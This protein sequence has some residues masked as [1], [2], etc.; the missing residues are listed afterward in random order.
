MSQ[1]ENQQNNKTSET[2]KVDTQAESLEAPDNESSLDSQVNEDIQK[3][4]QTLDVPDEPD[5]KTDPSSNVFSQNVA[6]EDPTTK[7]KKPNGPVF[8][9]LPLFKRFDR[10]LIIFVFVIIIVVVFGFYIVD[11]N[12]SPSTPAIKSQ[13]LTQSVLNQLNNTNVQVGSNQQ[14]LSVESNTIFSG[15]VLIKGGLQVA[16]ATNLVGGLNISNI[17]ISGN[18]QLNQISGN[19]INISGISTLKGQVIIGGGLNVSGTS[20]LSG[21]VNAGSLTVSSLQVNGDIQIAHH[22]DTSGLSPKIASQGSIGSGGTVSI[23][24][25]DTAGAIALNF[26]NSPTSGC[27]AIVTFN[28]SF[29]TTPEV[30]ISPENAA[31]SSLDYYVNNKTTSSFDICIS[32]NP[33]TETA[34]FD[35]FVIG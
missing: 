34:I 29:N 28:Q 2:A 18:S 25:T 21:A 23:N 24:G 20:T 12:K 5:A 14:I 26:G 9:I 33:N 31:A 8:N 15:S 10:Y 6:N 22:L 11:K 4:S 7:D 17:N 19:E 35:Y 27:I 13:T 3:S 16:G 32:S 1:D 30:I